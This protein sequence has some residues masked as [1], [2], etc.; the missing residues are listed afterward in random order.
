MFLAVILGVFGFIVLI[1]A[2]YVGANWRL[3]LLCS[4]A[5]VVSVDHID[6]PIS[7]TTRAPTTA[8]PPAS[9]MRSKRH[10]EVAIGST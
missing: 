1:L 4:E 6:G 7:D 2:L 3:A 8:S 10:A 9:K 5:Q